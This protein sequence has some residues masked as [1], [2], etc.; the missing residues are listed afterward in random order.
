MADLNQ[1]INDLNETW[2]RKQHKDLHKFFHKDV[3]MLPPGGSEPIIGVES[4]VESYIR[5]DSASTIHEF[6]TK[7]IRQFEHGSYT[8]CHL[9]F[10]VDFEVESGRFQEDGMEIYVIDS[11]GST[12]EIV[13]RTQIIHKNVG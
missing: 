8:V 7:E 9:S 2:R 12:P 10:H 4:M 5:F 11:S 6:R 13:W 1:F 3:V